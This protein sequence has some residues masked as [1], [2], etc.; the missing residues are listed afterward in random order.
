MINDYNQIS[1]HSERIGHTELKKIISVS[2]YDN[3]ET[4]Q[5]CINKINELKIKIDLDI[6]FED[7]FLYL[8]PKAFCIRFL[9]DAARYVNLVLEDQQNYT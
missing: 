1:Q 8:V 4:I 6:D 5:A 2:T 3:I 7:N 9:A